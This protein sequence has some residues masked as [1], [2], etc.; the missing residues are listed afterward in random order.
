MDNFLHNQIQKMETE[1]FPLDRLLPLSTVLKIFKNEYEKNTNKNS[2]FSDRK[3]QRLREGY[4]ALFVA[5]ALNFWERKDH[6]LHFSKDPQNDVNILSVKEMNDKK[7]EMWKLPCDIKEY[8]Q[9]SPDLKKFIEDKIIP[10]LNIYNIIIGT[11]LGIEDIRPIIKLIKE[12]KD[13]LTV[14]IVSSSGQDEDNFKIGIVTMVHP[15]N[16]IFQRD[17]NL[18]NEI[19]IDNKPI[20]VFQNF[21]R[22]K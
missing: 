3:Y 21:L 9:Y 7:S 4:F 19:K 20:L 18:N 22:D 16:E 15:N 14:W 13:R 12:Q 1:I 17:V 6:F 11:Y 2:F 10:K 5:T 8:T